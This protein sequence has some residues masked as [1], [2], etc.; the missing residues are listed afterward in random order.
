M[1]RHKDHHNHYS[2]LEVDQG[3][4][5]PEVNSHDLPQT[6][7]DNTLPEAISKDVY[8]EVVQSKKR[9]AICGIRKKFFWIALCAIITAVAIAVGVGVGVGV[10]VNSDS[11]SASTSTSTEDAGNEGGSAN[12]GNSTG[13]V[14]SF[15]QLA[16]EN[17]TD[18]Q[19]VE[20]SLVYYQD[21]A[22]DIW[23]ADLDTSTDNW[24]LAK[25]NTFDMDPKNGT[26]IAAVNWVNESVGESFVQG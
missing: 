5:L 15:S 14:A 8:P 4:Q 24:S 21:N 20:R 23:K 11:S 19:G 16:A 7:L 2:T 3:A 25:V 18:K 6:K 1:E 12:G 17:Y 10:G 22:L 9:S 26:P 13:S